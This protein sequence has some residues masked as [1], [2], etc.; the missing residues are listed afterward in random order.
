MSNSVTIIDLA[1]ELKI[2]P[3]TVS[4]ALR[5][6]PAIKQETKTLVQELAKKLG[7]QPNTLALSL[8]Y[9]KTN[10]IGIIVPEI[11]SY[12]FS[13]IICGIQDVLEPEGQH[14]IISQSNESYET[15]L[16]GI[17][18]FLS[19]RVDGMLISSTFNTNDYSHLEKL[20][21]NNVPVVVFDRDCEGYE[22]N[23]VLVDDYDGACQAVEHLISQGCKRIAHIAGSDQLSIARHRKNGYIDTL[24]KHGIAIDE[25]LIIE[26]KF[27]QMEDGIE[28]TKK[29]LSLSN[30]PDSIFAV[31]DAIAIGALSVL[32]ERGIQVPEEVALIGFDNDP[33]AKF[34]SPSLSTID[35]PVCEMGM[36]AARI[37]LAS[38]GKSD[39]NSDFRQE[40]LKPEL[41][42]RESSNRRKI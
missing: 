41:I 33:Y 12:F 21:Q 16:K 13:S 26:S 23:K 32:R 36:L 27:F 11:T 5:D 4:R 10:N 42:V 7:Y 14:V 34:S 2:S 18:T 25:E 6:H 38:I 37:L 17:E 3:S 22:M 20:R 40:I 1:K 35:Q 39:H 15:E 31:N 9:R 8:L 19:S 24:S 28:P 29:L 30:P